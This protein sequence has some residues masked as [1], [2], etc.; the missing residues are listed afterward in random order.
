MI[1]LKNV[2]GSFSTINLNNRLGSFLHA[3]GKLHEKDAALS[4]PTQTSL[5]RL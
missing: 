5:R 1:G 4:Q 3:Y 2:D